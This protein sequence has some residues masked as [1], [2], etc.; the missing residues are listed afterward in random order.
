MYILVV[1]PA[2][3]GL[4]PLMAASGKKP[5]MMPFD[6]FAIAIRITGPALRAA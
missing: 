4:F 6:P 2:E 1:G 5:H 3:D